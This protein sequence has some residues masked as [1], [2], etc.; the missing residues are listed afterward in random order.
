MLRGKVPLL[1]HRYDSISKDNKFWDEFL[2]SNIIIAD[3]E[4]LGIVQ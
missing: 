2:T 1:I 3:P 4:V